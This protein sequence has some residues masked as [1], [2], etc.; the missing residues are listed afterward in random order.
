MSNLRQLTEKYVD[1]F[2]ARDL[3]KVASFLAHDFELTDPDVTGLTPKKEV[4]RYIKDLFASNETLTFRAHNILVDGNTT[5]IH[6]TLILDLMIFDGV[7]L[8]AWENQKMRS[9][10]AYLSPRK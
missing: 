8:I 2:D 7:D 4:L 10:K 5:V 9:M 1:A 6:F 3:E